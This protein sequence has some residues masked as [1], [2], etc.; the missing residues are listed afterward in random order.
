MATKDVTSS[1]VGYMVV[2]TVPTCPACNATMQGSECANCGYTV[3]ADPVSWITAA[4]GLGSMPNTCPMCG[5][6]M[7]N[8]CPNCGF[9]T[10][11][12]IVGAML[13]WVRSNSSETLEKRSMP[14]TGKEA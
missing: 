4:G 1:T 3:S 13:P 6:G 7:N 8:E 10:S 14:V 5:H 11:K 12:D 2:S 9:T